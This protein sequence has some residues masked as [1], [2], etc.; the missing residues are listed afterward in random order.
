[1]KLETKMEERLSKHHWRNTK[2]TL[3][4]DY[5]IKYYYKNALLLLLTTNK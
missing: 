1:M 3:R 2:I 5:I 4:K